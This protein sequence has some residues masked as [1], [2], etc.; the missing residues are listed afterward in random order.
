MPDNK[1][2]VTVSFV[3]GYNN[4]INVVV[5]VMLGAQE[6]KISIEKKRREVGR[7]ERGGLSPDEEGER[8][9][10]EGHSQCVPWHSSME[11]NS[12]SEWRVFLIPAWFT[13]GSS[14]WAQGLPALPK[15]L[16]SQ[17]NIF[18]FATT[19]YYHSEL[20]EI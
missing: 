6:K 20:C 7:P 13:H 15:T 4:C 3:V 17:Y 11:A 9:K 19:E 5:E 16:M 18:V 14:L 2:H 10:L 1:H 8:E 12:L